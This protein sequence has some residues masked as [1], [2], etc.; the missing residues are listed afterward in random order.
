VDLISKLQ[1]EAC[2]EARDLHSKIFRWQQQTKTLVTKLA[3]AE[4]LRVQIQNVTHAKTS[5]EMQ[6]SDAN[7]TIEKL[8]ED[9]G[10][11]KHLIEATEENLRLARALNGASETKARGLQADLDLTN[12]Q[13]SLSNL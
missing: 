6:L 4:E 10:K 1:G 3:E 8:K 7:E 13:N 12:G 2:T 5:V 11:G 9:V